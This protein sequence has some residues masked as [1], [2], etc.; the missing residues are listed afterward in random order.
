VFK[1]LMF[2]CKN[3]KR[4]KVRRNQ[5]RGVALITSLLLL[6]LLT[7]MT[8]AMVLSSNS[9]MLINGYYRGF[10]GSF[11]S[12]D[13]GLTIARQQMINQLLAAGGNN[14]SATAQPI[15]PGTEGS[16]V[17]N[18]NTTYGAAFQSLNGGQ[19]A[20]SWPENFKLDTTGTTLS[21]PTCNV[22]GGGGT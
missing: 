20:Y 4:G 11:Y 10:R 14:F 17:S 8:V 7:G 3:L 5:S 18:V 12:A 15:P 6:L 16:V 21:A 19:G 2:A 9:D 1:R 13:S 22:I